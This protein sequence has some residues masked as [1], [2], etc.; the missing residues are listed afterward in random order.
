M[1]YGLS[2]SNFKVY[3]E[4]FKNSYNPHIRKLQLSNPFWQTQR[5]KADANYDKYLKYKDLT[6]I[7]TV[8][9]IVDR[10]TGKELTQNDNLTPGF[11]LHTLQSYS[12]VYFSWNYNI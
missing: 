11:L 4:T 2:S 6:D 7:A 10:K 9:M 12:A 3:Y 1:K 8:A 5:A